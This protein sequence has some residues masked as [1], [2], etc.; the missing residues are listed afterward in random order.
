MESSVKNKWQVRLAVLG[1]FLIGF[2]AGVMAV[3][4]YR[5]RA[6][7]RVSANREGRFDRL[8][9][10]LGLTEDQRTEV[11]AIFDEARTELDA[12]RKQSEPRLKEVRERTDERMRGVLT[13]EQWQQFQKLMAET[14][15]RRRHGGDAT[16][17]KPGGPEPGKPE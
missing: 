10:Q 1:I 15:A 12:I 7:E 13:D 6:V 9:N 16:G 3:N 17:D 2:I 11:R 5:G 8:V 4:V 14:R